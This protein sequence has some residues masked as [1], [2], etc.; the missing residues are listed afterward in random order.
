VNISATPTTQAE[1]LPRSICNGIVKSSTWHP[2]ATG[3]RK[4]ST[5]MS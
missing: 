3:A 1:E 2:A 5:K 4:P